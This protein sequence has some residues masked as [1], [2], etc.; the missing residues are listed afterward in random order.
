MPTFKQ[1][2][3]VRKRKKKRSEK[4]SLDTREV[5]VSRRKWS[6]SYHRNIEDNFIKVRTERTWGFQDR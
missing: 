1:Q 6:S 4:L 5:R 2:I 3:P